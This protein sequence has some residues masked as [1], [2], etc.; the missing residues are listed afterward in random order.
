MG[1]IEDYTMECLSSVFHPPPP[2][3]SLSLSLSLSPFLS[4]FSKLHLCIQQAGA[5]TKLVDGPSVVPLE[6]LA[7][8]GSVVMTV[9]EVTL[10]E[11]P[12]EQKEWVRQVSAFL[13]RYS[14]K[15]S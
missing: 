11:E 9:D 10:R 3:L 12:D 13:T 1:S 15:S 6:D 14:P 5:V 7:K 4:Q 2:P 8:K